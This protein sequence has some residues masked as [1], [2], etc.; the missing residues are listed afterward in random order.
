MQQQQ[1]LAL[2]KVPKGRK[3]RPHQTPGEARDPPSHAR[4]GAG[5]P[6]EVAMMLAGWWVVLLIAVGAA[7][8][9]EQL[10][11]EHP[12][13]KCGV[14]LLAAG[15]GRTHVREPAAYLASVRRA[16]VTSGVHKVLWPLQS[17]QY[18]TDALQGVFGCPWTGNGTTV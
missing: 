18:G 16:P 14:F 10:L 17:L 7:G 13:D 9:A 15:Q 6:L 8:A 5:S 1:Q 3:V 2:G 12:Y 11:E 4:R